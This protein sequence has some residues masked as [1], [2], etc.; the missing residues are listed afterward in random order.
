MAKLLTN[1]AIHEK[2]KGNAKLKPDKLTLQACVWMDENNKKHAAQGH[3]HWSLFNDQE[4][5]REWERDSGESKEN[6]KITPRIINSKV[7]WVV[8]RKIW[9][10]YGFRK[11]RKACTM[12]KN[13]K[14]KVKIKKSMRESI[15]DGPTVP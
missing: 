5:T 7:C 8:G 14:I 1:L 6:D 15:K 2:I 4:G 11:T 3:N 13:V 9:F 12:Q 10:W